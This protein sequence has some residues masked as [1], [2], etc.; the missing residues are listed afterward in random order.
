MEL[1]FD[2]KIKGLLK[3][4]VDAMYSVTEFRRKVF[5]LFVNAI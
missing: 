1:F 4:F 2:Y 5:V 3:R